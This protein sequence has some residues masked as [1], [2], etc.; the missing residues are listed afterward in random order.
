[1][2]AIALAAW[3]VPLAAQYPQPA[4]FQAVR[5]L[6]VV[7]FVG[8][9]LL[10]P[11]LLTHW[12]TALAAL[13]SGGTLLLLAS[14]LS[15][16]TPQDALP[17]LGYMT[18]WLGCLFAWMKALGGGKWRMAGSG[19]AAAFTAGGPLIWYLGQDL[20]STGSGKSPLAYGPLWPALLDPR[21]PWQGAW[22]FCIFLFLGILLAVIRAQV[23]GRTR[24]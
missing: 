5:I 23:S 14:V 1:M 3:R 22:A 15:G 18:L 17:I 4:E 7:Q 24:R 8:A 9:A 6:I 12:P 20:G 13:F 10:S 11:A 2:G 21:A 16:W 19:I